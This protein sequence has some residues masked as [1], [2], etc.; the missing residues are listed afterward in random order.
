[1]TFI[2]KRNQTAPRP[3]INPDDYDAD[4]DNGNK[5]KKGIETRDQISSEAIDLFY[6]K[7]FADTSIRQLINKVGKS[8]SVIYNHFAN[9]EDILFII[10]RRIGEKTLGMLAE[11]KQRNS[12]P[13]ACLKAMVTAMIHLV[14]HPSMVK[15]IAI[16][17]NEAHHLPTRRRKIINRQHLGIVHEFED[18]LVQIAMKR[19]RKSVHGKVAAFSIL[20]VINWFYMW[21]HKDGELSLDA[22]CS[23]IIQ[24]IFYGLD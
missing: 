3:T 7:G 14:S 10:T 11:I 16:F 15:E 23:E 18:V 6:E 1:M 2:M 22:I 12:D 4:I 8:S 20:S 17:R 21:Y 5:Y 19:G 24:F 9:K 13:E